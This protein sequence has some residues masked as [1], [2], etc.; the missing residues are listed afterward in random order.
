MDDFWVWWQSYVSRLKSR[1]SDEVALWI[2]RGMPGG[3]GTCPA[4]PAHMLELDGFAKEVWQ[5]A[6]E[7]QSRNR[8]Y[9]AEA[10][11]QLITTPVPLGKYTKKKDQ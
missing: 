3:P 5:A 7:S 6:Q 11:K 10:F 8:S 9:D 4:F 1:H 2:E